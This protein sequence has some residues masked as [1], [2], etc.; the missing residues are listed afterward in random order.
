MNQ[1]QLAARSRRQLRSFHQHVLDM[2]PG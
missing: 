1:G 2:S